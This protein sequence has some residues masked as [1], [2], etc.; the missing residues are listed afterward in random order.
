MSIILQVSQ[1]NAQFDVYPGQLNP[2]F[3]EKKA[4][5]FTALEGFSFYIDDVLIET[6]DQTGT[7]AWLW[8]PGFYAGEVAAEL[9]DDQGRTAAIYRL[10][11]SASDHKLGGQAF[12]AM[13]ESILDFD[14]ALVLGTEEAQFGIGHDGALTNPHLQYTRL[15][16][17]GDRLHRALKQ[18]AQRPL[19]TLKSDRAPVSAHTV[20]RLDFASVHQALRGP[21]G[22]ALL[23]PSSTQRPALNTVR[24]EVS[25]SYEEEDNP[26]NQAVGLVLFDVIRRCR[27][28][29]SGLQQ[30][31]AAEVVSD[32]RS[33]LT[34]RLVRRIAFTESLA[35]KLERLQR[36]RPFCILTARRLSSA[37]LN[38]ISAHPA[39]ARAYRFGW[40]ALRSGWLGKD[41]D[42][43]LWISPTWEIYERWC[44][45]TVVS[46]LQRQFPDL[47]WRREYRSVGL[48]EIVWQGAAADIIIEACYQARC[49]AIDQAAH[50]GFQSL[51][52]E[53]YPDIVVT[54]DSP[55]AKRFVV[56]DAKYR[57]ARA[58]V[59]DAMASAHIYHDSLRW[60]G[61]KPD[62]S[63][64]LIPR[65]QEVTML[66][67]PI[68]HADYGVGAWQIGAE[69][70]GETLG[71]ELKRILTAVP[72]AAAP[73]RALT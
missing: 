39:Y 28:V 20:K 45:V 71:I 42:E 37:G 63:L 68:Y 59:L 13:V 69:S 14:P 65:A 19:T 73:A 6:V 4:Y 47:V 27:Q 15:R 48:K 21:T 56:F 34:P 51:S 16:R 12:A 35:R 10:D 60:K 53:R 23:H 61:I 36:A 8:S 55:S 18:I 24:F 32:T 50:R 54:L 43:T 67:S 70:E 22:Q 5:R 62:A 29:V 7:F 44:F 41:A 46:Q 31:A 1:G 52:R 49:P 26:A 25:R 72:I 2:G 17:Y 58:S 66:A 33:T 38:A 40:Y 64:L 9:L 30:A 3:M 11:V 57:S